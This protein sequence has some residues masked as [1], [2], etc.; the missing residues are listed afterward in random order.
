MWIT[1]IPAIVGFAGVLVG[2]II[3]TGASYWLAV[4]KEA[5]EA[6]KDRISRAVELLCRAH[7][8]VGF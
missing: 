2:A 6:T 5:A 4:R 3:T 1:L 7:S 8:V